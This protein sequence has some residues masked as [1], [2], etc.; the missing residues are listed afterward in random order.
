MKI[1]IFINFIIIIIFVY[2]DNNEIEIKNTSIISNKCY[3]NLNFN[4]TINLTDKNIQN[5]TGTIFNV[6]TSDENEFTC[7][8]F[9]ANEETLICKFNDSLE[10]GIYNFSTLEYII[11]DDNY[12]INIKNSNI[13]FNYAKNY[14]LIDEIL[15]QN[16]TIHLDHNHFFKI[17]FQTMN[18]EGHNYIIKLENLDNESEK[19]NFTEENITCNFGIM[20]INLNLIGN[21]YFNLKENETKNFS[22]NITNPCYI[23]ENFKF[24]ITLNRSCENCTIESELLSNQPN[25]TNPFFDE[26]FNIFKSNFSLILYILL[27][28]FI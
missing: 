2:S 14:A 28:L 20:Y 7:K 25:Y 11:D 27:L 12:E 8:N 26:S 23:R 5:I 3:N 13:T 16:Q 10:N 15:T 6:I 19:Y 22:V 17:I 1:L 9:N 24:N 21:N 4:F 18:V